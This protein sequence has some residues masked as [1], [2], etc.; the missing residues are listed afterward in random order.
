MNTNDRK[1]Y[2]IFVSSTFVDL[3]DERGKVMETILNFD[4]FP[5]G[6]ELFPAM[7]EEQ[8]EYIKRIIDDSDYYLLI[9]GG[10]YG[11]VDESGVSWT[12]RE[13]DYAVSKGI[14][15]MVFDHKDFTKL[16]ADKTDQDNGK[17][18]KLVAFKKKAS[19]GRLIGKWTNADDLAL[20]VAK[21]LPKVLEQYPR[22]GWVRA[23]SVVNVDS[24]NEINRLKKE[25]EK[26][27]N[28]VKR[29]ETK[30]E[31]LQATLK[32]KDGNYRTLKSTYHIAQQEIENLI[33]LIKSLEREIENSKAS[34]VTIVTRPEVITIPGTNVSF[35]MIH[36]DGGTFM[37]GANDDDARLDEIP[38][39]E[40]TLSDYWIGETQVTQELW[41]AVMGKNPSYFKEDQNLP[42]EFVSW[43]D[44]QQFIERLNKMTN[45]VFRLPSEAQ[46]EFAARGGNLGKE[47][48]Y[49][50]AGRN[51]DL[52]KIAWYIEN[53]G[54]KTH[55]V[56]RLCANQLGL[57]DMSGNVREWCQ[58]FYDS[59]Y[60]RNSPIIEPKGPASGISHV[61]RGG[62]WGAA[63]ILCRVWCRD[64]HGSDYYYIDLGL[65]LAL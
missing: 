42:V 20:A 45:K 14:H 59:D 60:Y 43:N 19:K 11:S 32:Q 3:E 62:G 44:C 25:I 27:Q 61:V 49:R 51:Y 65:R 46:W 33:E 6:M 54:E 63:E 37:M 57:Y 56:A 39:H 23:D 36:V 28:E 9:I 17:R 24:Q 4:C 7:D 64:R 2:Q 8:F 58:D 47:T 53:S 55:P 50:Y 16:P 48:G 1:R 5:A 12:E 21:S 34:P 41:Q 22:I 31:G 13:Y 40:V 35:K 38:A 29:L 26:H 15:V 30:V 52:G 18:D 10:R